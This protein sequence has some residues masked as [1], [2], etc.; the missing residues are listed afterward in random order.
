[1]FRFR[2]EN[3]VVANVSGFPNGVF[4]PHDKMAEEIFFFRKR[5]LPQSRQV[6]FILSKSLVQLRQKYFVEVFGGSGNDNDVDVDFLRVTNTAD[7]AGLN[8]F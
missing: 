8:G 2:R 6:H 7:F 3:H 1:M 4:I 5:T